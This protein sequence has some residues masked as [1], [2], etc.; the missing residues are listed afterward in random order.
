MRYVKML[1]ALIL[2]ICIYSSLCYAFPSYSQKA[3]SLLGIEI[4]EYLAWKVAF[5]LWKA[6]ETK[7][8]VEDYV[9]DPA[10]NTRENIEGRHIAPV[11]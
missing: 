6:E 3:D 4:H 5:V 8:E 2:V 7:Q 9:D 11:E 1:L 10:P